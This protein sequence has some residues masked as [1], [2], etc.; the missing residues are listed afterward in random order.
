MD[1]S[2]VTPPLSSPTGEEVNPL[3]SKGRGG[4]GLVKGLSKYKQK[5]YIT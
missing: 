5:L 3:S 1:L 2:S 4:E